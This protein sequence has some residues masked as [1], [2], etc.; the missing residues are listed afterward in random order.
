MTH[1]APTDSL[2]SLLWI[3][4]CKEDR[5]DQ[6]KARIRSI[7]TKD[8]EQAK[9]QG[10]WASIFHR[11]HS[12]NLLVVSRVRVLT[13][14]DRR[15]TR[16]RL[17]TEFFMKSGRWLDVE[18]TIETW[19]GQGLSEGETRVALGVRTPGAG[20]SPWEGGSMQRGAPTGSLDAWD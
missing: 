11:V 5:L 9:C 20:G 7:T 18:A 15:V 2:A 4:V 6:P 3:H 8:Q 17:I 12:P 10:Y 13:Q 19:P 1:S 16:I 14:A